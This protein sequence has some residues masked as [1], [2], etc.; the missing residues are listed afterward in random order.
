[1]NELSRLELLVGNENINKL[2]NSTVLV[3][4]LGGV[5]GYATEALVRSGIGNIIIV[6]NDII[7]VTNLNRQL[8][9]HKENIGLYKTDEWE[10]RIKQ[11]NKSCNVTKITSFIDESNIDKLFERKIDYIIDACDTIE[12]KFLLI[13]LSSKKNIKL[14]S[15]M[16]TGNKFHPEKLKIED[17]SKTSYDPIA[18]ILRKKL[19]EDGFFKKVSVVFS[20]EAPIV[21]SSNII[22]S[23]SYVP[24]AAGLLCASFVIN[25]IVG[26]KW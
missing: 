8:I 7:D 2:K 20:E 14:I 13:K 25:S 23:N 6:D 19:K 17:I 22:G 3:I 21:N 9:A 4:G 18:R 10:K 16:G 1:M 5:G 12:T 26:V 24:A 15:S 11:I